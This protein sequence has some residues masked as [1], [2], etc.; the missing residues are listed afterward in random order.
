MGVGVCMCGCVR[1][2]GL[3]SGLVCVLSC[4]FNCLQNVISKMLTQLSA[5]GQDNCHVLKAWSHVITVLGIVSLSLVH[6]ACRPP[7][8]YSN[9][10][11]TTVQCTLQR[12]YYSEVIVVMCSYL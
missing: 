8:A 12:A 11:L 9:H 4:L 7:I 1:M 10:S 3:G 6:N 2:C 5:R